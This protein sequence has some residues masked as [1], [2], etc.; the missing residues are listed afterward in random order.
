MHCCVSTLCSFLS[1][2]RNSSAYDGPSERNTLS[3][4][5][6]GCLSTLFNRPS[7]SLVIKSARW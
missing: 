2:R 7:S 4:R 5:V 3:I 6:L 1:S